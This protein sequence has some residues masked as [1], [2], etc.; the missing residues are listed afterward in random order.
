M[1]SRHISTIQ[2]KIFIPYIS[3]ILV[4][5]IVTSCAYYFL[6]YNTFLKNFTQNSRQHTKIVSSQITNYINIL[7]EQQVRILNSEAIM[8]YIF[9]ESKERSFAAEKDFYNNM[10]SIV[11]YDFK[12]FHINILNMTD[13]SLITFGQEYLYHPYEISKSVQENVIDVVFAQ[14]GKKVILPPLPEKS[15]FLYRGGNGDSTFSIC[16]SFS[17][18]P[19][20]PPRAIIEMQVSLDDTSSLI[21][22][23]LASFRGET[24]SVLLYDSDWN[25]I[26]PADLSR[27]MAD[28]YSRLALDSEMI[29]PNPLTGEKEVVTAYRS[30]STG[31]TT[32]LVTPTSY[33]DENK[34]FFIRVSLYIALSMILVLTLISYQVAKSISLPIT[35]LRKHIAT[36]EL[37]RIS[38]ETDD[39]PHSN[40]NELELL[41]QAYNQMQIRLK[42][43]L[44]DIVQSRTLS[45]HSQMMALQAQ[46]DS[47]FLYNTLTIISIIAEE[48]DDMQVS[49][50]CLKL[51][52]MLRYIT[53]DLS[54]QTT[55]GQE[56]AHTMDYSDLMAIRFGPEIIFHYDVDT[57]LNAFVIPRLIL[58]PLVENSIK[59]SRTAEK[60]LEVWI[61]VY[62]EDGYWIATI[63]DN[64][65]GFDT[66]V[67]NDI[68]KKAEALNQKNTYTELSLGGMGIANI[69]LR[70]K[71]FYSDRFVFDIT[72]E[73]IGSVVKIGGKLHE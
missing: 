19:L 37:D 68:W 32:L 7:N 42:K 43:S 69:Y 9:E 41:S 52:R 60:Q 71:L 66:E 50:M 63:R 33:I 49:E 44:D 12:F 46:M 38:T 20:T 59:Y 35:K 73:S 34:N 67:L 45:I 6:S 28:H 39:T 61:H 23:T 57:S 47:H 2:K 30:S 65:K 56:I 58:Q 29:F 48:H 8:Q 3:I 4:L 18:H 72:N 11:G 1:K 31:L 36:L 5:I 70:M 64:G 54:K 62:E 14:N 25:L 40:L 21:S 13:N 53:E 27:E 51:T 24:S 17:R 22:D 16:R 26:F 10:Y 15:A 55:L